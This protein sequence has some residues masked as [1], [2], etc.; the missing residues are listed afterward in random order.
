MLEKLDKYVHPKLGTLV[1]ELSGAPVLVQVPTSIEF[2][3]Q[4]GMSSKGYFAPVVKGTGGAKQN[5]HLHLFAASEKTR[6]GNPGY[7]A[8]EDASLLM[9]AKT[10]RTT[11]SW[12]RTANCYINKDGERDEVSGAWSPFVYAA[13]DKAGKLRLVF[14]DDAPEVKT[15]PSVACVR[16]CACR[17]RFSYFRASSYFFSLVL[18]V[19][20]R[21]TSTIA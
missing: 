6:P 12:D 3:T 5:A 2:L 7:F 11:G 19:C 20:R 1:T 13:H 4:R 14:P 17:A 9:G 16:A 18:V 21:M 8:I 15:N 10:K